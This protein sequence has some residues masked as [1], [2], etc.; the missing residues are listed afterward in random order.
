MAEPGHSHKIFEWLEVI[1][2]IQPLYFLVRARTSAL[3][4]SDPLVLG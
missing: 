2:Q 1:A 4:K 3:T